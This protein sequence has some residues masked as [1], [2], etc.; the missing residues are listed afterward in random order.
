MPLC[1]NLIGAGS[2]SGKVSPDGGT[3]SSARAG[4]SLGV[5]FKDLA[6]DRA[7]VPMGRRAADRSDRGE[8]S[9]V[10]ER[11]S[12]TTLPGGRWSLVKKQIFRNLSGKRLTAFWGGTIDRKRRCSR[13]QV[14][15][16]G[17]VYYTGHRIV[18][19][20]DGRQFVD[21]SIS[22]EN[23]APYKLFLDGKSIG[24]LEGLHIGNHFRYL[25][26]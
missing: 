13:V 3:F 16:D 8:E 10:C 20:K 25:S 12:T 17:V 24:V 1:K 9:E 4:L 14:S 7:A 21:L 18:Q 11:G 6:L 22:D 26:M 23:N 2:S 15:L 19:A 5:S